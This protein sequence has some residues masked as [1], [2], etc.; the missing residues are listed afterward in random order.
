MMNILVFVSAQSNSKAAVEYGSLIVSKTQSAVTLLTVIKEAKDKTEAQQ[1]IDKAKLWMPGLDVQTSIRV[2]AEVDGIL[3]EL[4]SRTYDLI[5][6]KARQELQIIDFLRTKLGR[7][8]ARYSP[9]SVLVVKRT[10]SKIDRIL[11]CTS[12]QE[13]A[14]NVIKV[15]AQLT[16]DTQ[17]HATLLYVT[18]PVP[19]MYTGLTKMEETLPDMLQTATPVAKSLQQGAIILSDYQV[20]ADLELRHG[21]VSEEILNE[22]RIGEF[23]LI[24]LGASRA[25]VELSGL[26]MVD[27]TKRIV[28]QAHCPVL[29][30]RKPD[31]SA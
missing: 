12:G 28:D 13:N 21:S 6:L 1:V 29:V 9:I 3:K 8:V 15:G 16:Q 24:V 4:H 19:S 7:R 31:A 18:D 11:I 22:A 10:Y 14:D 26:L 17:A 2:G 25:S 5:I 20:E 27:V 23:D 30:V